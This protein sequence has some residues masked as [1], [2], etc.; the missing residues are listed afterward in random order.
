MYTFLALEGHARVV[1]VSVR[2][3]LWNIS[4]QMEMFPERFSGNKA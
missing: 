3:C 1:R 4:R 2:F